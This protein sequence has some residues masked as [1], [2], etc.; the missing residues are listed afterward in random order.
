MANITRI[1]VQ[2]ITANESPTGVSGWVYVNVAGREFSLDTPRN[3]FE[4]G[5]NYTYIFGDGANVNEAERNDPRVPQLDTDD[6]DRY[7][8]Y[9]RYDAPENKVDEIWCLE[10]VTIKVNPASSIPAQFD[11]PRLAG[12]AANQKIW[13]GRKYGKVVNLRRI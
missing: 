3:D 1:D 6:L 12:G 2:L 7:P 9:L 11:N 10:R 13:L 4:P 8:V 5:D